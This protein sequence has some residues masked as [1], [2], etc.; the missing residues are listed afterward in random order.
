MYFVY[1]NPDASKHHVIGANRM[2]RLAGD[3]EGTFNIEVT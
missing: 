2:S 3:E 1:K